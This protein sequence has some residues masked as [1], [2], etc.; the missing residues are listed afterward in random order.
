MNKLHR[1]L[2]LIISALIVVSC[3]LVVQDGDQQYYSKVD[4]L[5]FT[6]KIVNQNTGEW[7]NNRLVILFLK[8]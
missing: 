3:A 5:L 1:Y 2:V 8:K 6:G 7:V 4:Y